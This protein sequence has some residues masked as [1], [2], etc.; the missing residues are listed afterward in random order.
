LQEDEVIKQHVSEQGRRKWAMCALQVPGR[1]GKQCNVR[2]KHTL[3][4]T[5]KR[6]PW[7]AEEDLAICKVLQRLG[8]RWTEIA[9]LLPGR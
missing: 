4:P 6:G 5:L 3:D 7:S 9:K 2:F 8:N 1:S